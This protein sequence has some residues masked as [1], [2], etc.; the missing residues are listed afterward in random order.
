MHQPTATSL[1]RAS[2]A[3]QA[4]RGHGAPAEKREHPR[5]KL[6]AMYSLIRVR[7]AD[8]QSELAQGHIYDVSRSGLRFELDHPIDPGTRVDVRAMLPG[9]QHASIMAHGTVVRVHDDKD[10]PGPVRM[11]LRIDGFADVSYEA[12]FDEYLAALD[13]PLAA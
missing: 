10:E 3:P 5:Y 8:R 2:K 13:R 11:G 12:R 6:P 4:D 1:P 7:I 9:F